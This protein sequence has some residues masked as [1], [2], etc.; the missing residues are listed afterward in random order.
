MA[1]AN[2]LR[3]DELRFE[4]GMR[5]QK[6][7]PD[8]TVDAMRRV[9]AALLAEEADGVEHQ[10]ALL[11]IDYE[12]ELSVVDVKL[13]ELNTAI[14]VLAVEADDSAAA[15]VRALL[16]H[17]NRRLSRLLGHSGAGKRD[18]VKRMLVSLKDAVH[19]FRLAGEGAVYNASSV[20]SVSSFASSHTV[21]SSSSSAT[22]VLSSPS[23]SVHSF[24]SS[25][26]ATSTPKSKKPNK[27]HKIPVAQ[28][29]DFQKWGLNFSG[30]ENV[31][32][33]SFILDAEEKAES[34]GLDLN[35][36]V[37]GAPEFFTG[38]AKVWFRTVK[39]QIDSWGE[40][41]N[42]LRTEFLPLNYS[43]NLWEEVRGRLQGEQESIGCYIANML[44]LFE[45]LALMGPIKEEIKLNI[46]LKN[47]AS[48][49]VKGL[50]SQKVLSISHL[51]L[52]GRELEN[53]RFQVERYDNSRR[54]PLME[55]EFAYKGK[56]KKALVHETV[57][58]PEVAA[59]VHRGGGRPPL[60]C[61]RCSVSGHRFRDCEAKGEFPK[62]C[63]GC[64]RKDAVTSTCP[65][66]KERRARREEENKSSPPPPEGP[67]QW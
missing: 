31:S 11:P 26:S 22:T 55:P 5:G 41:K 2:R 63:W 15:R 46:I 1:Y 28:Q 58:E 64:G 50:V 34:R 35:C 13:T 47:L 4:C 25:P 38:R 21:H 52:L 14:D 6:Q 33:L 40:M 44:S 27:P 60:T 59:V 10:D 17:C 30:A 45:R 12:D 29:V 43:D 8:A 36:L 67:N 48:F 7:A 32:V 54:T 65:N 56:A 42:L 23:V 66:C 49:Y 61:W 9:F 16:S 19:R 3:A 24:K 18:R 57:V 51:K 39:D 62:F 37:R 20:R 53:A